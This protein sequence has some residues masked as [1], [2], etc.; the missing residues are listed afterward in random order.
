MNGEHVRDSE[1]EI[2]AAIAEVMRRLEEDGAVAG[3]TSKRLRFRWRE[4]F[5]RLVRSRVRRPP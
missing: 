1:E 3:V 2:T 4:T 5:P